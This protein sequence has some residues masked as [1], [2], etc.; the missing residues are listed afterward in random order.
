MQVEQRGAPCL[1]DELREDDGE[2]AGGVGMEVGQA[3]SF[4]ELRER[5]PGLAGEISFKF[6]QFPGG[7][8]F[9][10]D[11]SAMVAYHGDF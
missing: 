1:G 4:G 9:P 8:Y 11:A 10:E 3:I 2:T 6:R 5:E 7:G